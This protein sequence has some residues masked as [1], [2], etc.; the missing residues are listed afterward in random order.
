MDTWLDRVGVSGVLASGS[1]DREEKQLTAP[2]I[3]PMDWAGKRV[4]G[5]IA[6]LY[7][8]YGGA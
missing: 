6:A 7:F 8:M 2:A 3:F 5:Q 1:G 4:T